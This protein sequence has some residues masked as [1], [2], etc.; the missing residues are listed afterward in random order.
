VAGHGDDEYEPVDE[1][2]IEAW[3]LRVEIEAMESCLADRLDQK[4]AN[5]LR[6]GIEEANK[7]LKELE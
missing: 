3:K 5:I 6:R 2:W 1:K 7:R 4:G